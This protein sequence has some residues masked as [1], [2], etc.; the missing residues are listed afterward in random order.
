LKITVFTSRKTKFRR[1]I[2]KIFENIVYEFLKLIKIYHKN[3]IGG[4]Y[5]VTRSVLAGLENNRVEFNYNPIFNFQINEVVLI[6]DGV[7]N[8]LK[9][10]ELKKT[11]KLLS[12]HVGPNVITRA[13]DY[14][15]IISNP[16]ID[17]IIV[18]SKWVESFYKEDLPELA[19]KR[20]IIWA[21][22]VKLE[23]FFNKNLNIN[24]SC[25][26]Y[27]KSGDIKLAHKV[28]D[29]LVLQNCRIY[30]I[31]YGNYKMDTY[32]S[33]LKKS[34]FSI[35]ISESESQG[36][37]MFESWSCDV[38]T[39]VWR[40]SNRI[41]V[42]NKVIDYHSTSPYLNSETG[43]FFDDYNSFIKIYNEYKDQLDK[44]NPRNFVK[45]K[46]SDTESI[47]YLLNKLNC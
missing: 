38:P 41:N 17:S 24:N 22:G 47:K 11:N 42:K 43:V 13:I 31:E 12:I 4:H 39:F 36:I 32:I 34:T 3:S 44:F 9:A 45:K 5:A 1:T 15:S 10:I 2:L 25:L 37:A 20:F 40:N 19:Q 21:A 7:D 23:N 8:L 30:F 35:F 27:F 29:F 46:F 14:N 28:K 6:L 18:P 16:H 33:L 26:I